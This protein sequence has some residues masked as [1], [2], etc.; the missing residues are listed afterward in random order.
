MIAPP[1]VAVPVQVTGA[2]AVG[3]MVAPEGL[4]AHVLLN[5]GSV[6]AT[7]AA[8]KPTAIKA[9]DDFRALDDLLPNLEML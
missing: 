9:R 1:A 6:I 3:L 7:N 5:A 2:E 4:D 8:I